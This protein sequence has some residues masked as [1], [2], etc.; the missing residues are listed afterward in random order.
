MTQRTRSERRGEQ[1]GFALLLVFAMAAAVAIMLF[2]QIPRYAFE[3][4][5]DREQLLM[6]RGDEY[7][8]AVGRYFVK[9]KK[10]PSKMEDLD[11]TNNVR[12][13]RRH[14]LDP[15]T[16]KDDWR[17][18]HV[19]PTGVLT[20]SLVTKAP[21]ALDAK[22]A[23]GKDKDGKDLV[24]QVLGPDGQPV[25]PDGSS[26]GGNP[27]LRRRPDISA[28][29]IGQ[30]AR[31]VDPND[32]NAQAATNYQQFPGQINPQT[33]QPYP[34]GVNPQGYAPAQGQFP[35]QTPGGQPGAVNPYGNQI[36][37]Q[38]QFGQQAGQQAGQQFGQQFGQQ[39][40]QQF[41]Q[42]VGQL[43][44]QQYG[45]QSGQQPGPPVPGGANPAVNII[46]NLLTQPRQPPAGI[47]PA[48][49]GGIDPSGLS[50]QQGPSGTPSGIGQG[51]TIG[52]QNGANG[53]NGSQPNALGAGGIAGVA[54]KQAGKGIKV[55][56][57]R[58]KYKEW[59]FVFDPRKDLVTNKA[60]LGQQNP[61]GI[62]V[63]PSLTPGQ[64][65]GLGTGQTTG[66]TQVPSQ[67]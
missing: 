15:M 12:F 35:G 21:G 28:N 43:S 30:G 3:A 5:R 53:L 59:E 62:G 7:K 63:N 58:S 51:F 26:M 55:Y 52:N 19:G 39:V 60:A 8:K 49:Q 31:P 38:P 27:A 14:Y 17:I 61:G 65:N 23:D 50:A 13:L 47:F 6:D 16:G 48:G 54:S 45:Q 57:E 11:S 42:P 18:L 46:Q 29:A 22:N 56:N 44:G 40:G 24:T 4:Q 9:F 2:M 33:G 66:T 36:G 64:N 41:G 25:N 34:A 10:Y 37:Q 67:Q 32:P 1:S 20:D